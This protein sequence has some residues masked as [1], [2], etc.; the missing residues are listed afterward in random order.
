VFI[1]RSEEYYE[2]IKAIH[3]EFSFDVMVCDVAFSAIPFVKE[4]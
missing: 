1:L 3:E 4:K 2:D